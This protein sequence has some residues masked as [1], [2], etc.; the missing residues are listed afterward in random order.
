ME[1]KCKP[2]SLSSLPTVDKTCGLLL[3]MG[4]E[5]LPLVESTISSIQV[6]RDR[7][8]CEVHVLVVIQRWKFYLFWWLYWKIY[9][10][11][12]YFYVNIKYWYI[13]HFFAVYCFFFFLNLIKFL[14]CFFSPIYWQSKYESFWILH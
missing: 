14:H 3:A 2:N 10:F 4:Q 13:L 1:N 7:Q 6:S 9:I 12:K 5:K 11:F 8:L